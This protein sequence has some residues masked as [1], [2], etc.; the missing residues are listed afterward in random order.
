MVRA[1]SIT[2]QGVWGCWASVFPKVTVGGYEVWFIQVRRIE[3]NLGKW[4]HELKNEKDNIR[5]VSR[6]RILYTYRFQ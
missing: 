2:G 1:Y 6:L 3:D 4:S 5:L